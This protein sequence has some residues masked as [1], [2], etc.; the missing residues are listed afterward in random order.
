MASWLLTY[1]GW[2][3]ANRQ[4]LFMVMT[5]RLYISAGWVIGGSVYMLEL[6]ALM[7][8]SNLCC[9]LVGGSVVCVNRLGLFMVMTARLFI[10]AGLVV[11]GSV[12]VNR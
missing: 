7:T 8:S 3:V 11:G 5:S 2:V 10:C 6:S 1:A 4:G 9:L 12:Y